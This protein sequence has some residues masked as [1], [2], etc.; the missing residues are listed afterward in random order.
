MAAQVVAS[1]T[2]LSSTELVLVMSDLHYGVHMSRI[3][4]VRITLICCNCYYN[5]L[6]SAAYSQVR[7]QWVVTDIIR[8]LKS[9]NLIFILKSPSK[10]IK[11]P[12]F[13]GLY[14]YNNLSISKVSLYIVTSIGRVKCAE[15]DL[16]LCSGSFRVGCFTL[17]SYS[18][19]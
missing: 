17:M 6:M 18:V 14:V 13:I 4:R 5:R 2:V 19:F 16:C 9:V 10:T 12:V 15:C 8:A 7:Q 11:E 1:R 3:W